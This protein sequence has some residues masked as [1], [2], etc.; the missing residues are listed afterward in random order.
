MII[1]SS[2]G[3]CVIM[4]AVT[5]I[6]VVVVVVMGV[7]VLVEVIGTVLVEVVVVR[8]G[9]MAEVKFAT[10]AVAGGFSRCAAFDCR[11]MAALNRDR[12]LQARMPSYH[13]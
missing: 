9:V 6:T 5:A 1:A 11:P 13:V 7:L 4:V 8:V 2:L 3:L 12:V 10:P